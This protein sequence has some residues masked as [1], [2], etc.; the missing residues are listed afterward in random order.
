MS[1]VGRHFGVRKAHLDDSSSESKGKFESHAASE[2]H[3]N[4][5]VDFDNWTRCMNR[6]ATIKSQLSEEHA[7]VIPQDRHYIGCI[8]RAKQ[9]LSLRGHRECRDQNDNNPGSFIG[10]AKLFSKYDGILNSEFQA[11]PNNPH[12]PQRYTEPTA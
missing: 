10:L 2:T 8:S 5:S 6:G 9:G 3:K 12:I 7:K 11:G 1:F 4:A